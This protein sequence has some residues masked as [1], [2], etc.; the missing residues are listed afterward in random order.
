MGW[1]RSLYNIL[2][3]LRTGLTKHDSEEETLRE[4]DSED[5]GYLAFSAR[6]VAEDDSL[7]DD[8]LSTTPKA[9]QL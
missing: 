1:L 6:Q 7:G 4:V 2:T 3:N 9:A 5:C 8:V